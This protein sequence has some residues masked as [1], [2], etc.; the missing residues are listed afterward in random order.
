MVNK[1]IQYYSSNGAKLVYLLLLD[2]SK[3]FDKVSVYT[4]FTMLLDKKMCPPTVKLLYYIYTNQSCHVTWSNNRYKTFN[5]SNGFT[6]GD[7][8]SPLL[9]SIYIDNLFLELLIS[10]LGCHVGLTYAC[11]LGYADDSALIAPSIYQIKIFLFT[12]TNKFIVYIRAK[13]SKVCTYYIQ[14]HLL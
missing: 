2:A 6:Q 14:T 3:A 1:T 10:G 11:V 4:L 9:F 7:V 5:I 12:R 8:I 13:C